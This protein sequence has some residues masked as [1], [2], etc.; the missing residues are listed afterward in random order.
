M[1][2]IKNWFSNMLPLDKPYEYQGVE[3]FT[4]ENFYQAMKYTDVD[5]RRWIASLNPYKAKKI[6]K[7]EAPFFW[8]EVKLGVM[9]HIL[10]VKFARGTSWYDKLIA[11]GDEEIVEWNNWGDTYWGRDINTGLGK[12]HLGRL[13]MKIRDE[14][15]KS[16]LGKGTK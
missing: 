10:R 14:H 1:A 16:K 13:L 9:G 7:G 5:T 3:Y 15:K 11:T 2:W 12:N 4:A 6:A 8:S